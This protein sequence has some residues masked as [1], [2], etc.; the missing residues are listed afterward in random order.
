MFLLKNQ[1]LNAIDE[2][3][4]GILA[5][6]KS[7]IATKYLKSCIKASRSDFF[8]SL[9]NDGDAFGHDHHYPTPKLQLIV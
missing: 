8:V 6:T 2:S 4:L 3:N 1:S 5:T 9:D 7:I